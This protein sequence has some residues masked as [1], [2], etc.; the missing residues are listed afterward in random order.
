MYASTRGWLEKILPLAE[1]KPYKSETNSEGLFKLMGS[2]PLYAYL[3]DLIG[4]YQIEGRVENLN[5]TEL[6]TAYSLWLV[7][8]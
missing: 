5:D 3:G 4:V 8:C 1:L 2:Y 6:I 7:E